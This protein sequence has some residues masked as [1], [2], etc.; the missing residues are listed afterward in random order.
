MK[1]F[2]L[3]TTN[4]DKVVEVR[5]GLADL[6]GWNFMVQPSNIPEAE[7][8]GS[9]FLENA[10]LKAVHASHYVDDLVLGDDSG[11]CVDALDGRP[12]IYSARYDKDRLARIERLL[13]E[14][15]DVPDA[16]RTARFVCVL[17][18]V[19]QGKVVW[20]GEGQSEGR[21]TREPSG[22]NGFGYDPV[23]WVPEYGCTMADLPLETKNKV[24]HRGRALEKLREFL[25]SQ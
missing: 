20:T 10:I 5:A 13:R 23:F 22:M 9:T 17:A 3:A 14:L 1:Q 6:S 7:E 18:L 11:L 25:I 19:R 8:T 12:G 4:P 2:V 24:S 16:A 21:I 15:K